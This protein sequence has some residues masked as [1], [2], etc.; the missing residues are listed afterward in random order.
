MADFSIYL[1]LAT[2]NPRPAFSLWLIPHVV[3]LV[4]PILCGIFWRQQGVV[5]LRQAMFGMGLLCLLSWY[6]SPVATLLSRPDAA[7]FAM[8][9]WRERCL[10]S[11]LLL[12]CMSG[13]VT[14][15]SCKANLA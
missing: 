6:I 5:S 4:V 11:S 14:W 3:C 10:G 15:I 1:P 9:F 7:A 13:L 12:L 2:I 8:N